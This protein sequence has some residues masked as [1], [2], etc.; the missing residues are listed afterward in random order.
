DGVLDEQRPDHAYGHLEHRRLRLWTLGPW[1]HLHVHLQHSRLVP[2]PLHNPPGA[3][4]RDE[5]GH[6][7]PASASASTAAASPPAPPPP[8][9]PASPSTPAPSATAT[10]GPLPCPEGARAAPRS[11]EAEN[12]AAALLG[13]PDPPGSLEALATPP[14][15][16]AVAKA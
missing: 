2:V 9:P 15:D 12:P 7:A 5:H 14:R 4:D 16:R 3:D 11:R 1:R 10:S 8:S 6:G 13:G